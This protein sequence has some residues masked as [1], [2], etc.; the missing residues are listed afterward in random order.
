MA[1]QPPA[2]TAGAGGELD[3]PWIDGVI[4]KLNGLYNRLD[5][6]IVNVL[7]LDDI[8]SIL[9]LVTKVIMK[10]GSLVEV[11]LPIKVVGDIHGQYQVSF[12]IFPLNN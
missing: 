3:I 10:E 5:V 8:I 11:E 9:T 7:T 2:P 12:Y 4:E 6:G 1:A